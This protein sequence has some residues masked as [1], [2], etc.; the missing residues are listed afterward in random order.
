M[1]ATPGQRL[2]WYTIAACL[3]RAGYKRHEQGKLTRRYV[4]EVLQHERDRDGNLVP[5]YR[6]D[7]RVGKPPT[8]WAEVYRRRKFPEH[9]IAARLRGEV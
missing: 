1:A 9:L 8:D 3:E 7:R 6:E 4:T 2:S 5:Q